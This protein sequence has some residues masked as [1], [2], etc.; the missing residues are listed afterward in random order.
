MLKQMMEGFKLLFEKL[1][2]NAKE[3]QGHLAELV[4]LKK[5]T[6]EEEISPDDPHYEEKMRLKELQIID[7][8]ATSLVELQDEFLI[9][10]KN[11]LD[12]LL[13]QDVED[14]HEYENK[15]RDQDRFNGMD[16]EKIDKILI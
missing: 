12:D 3:V 15:K 8:G 10:T 2:E 14:D 7:L 5:P 11:H 1:N 16:E 13:K 4:D 6:Y 9:E